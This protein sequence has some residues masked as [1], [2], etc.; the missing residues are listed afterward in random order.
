M[1]RQAA[2]DETSTVLASLDLDRVRLNG[3]TVNKLQFEKGRLVAPALGPKKLVGA[4]L[5][6]TSS[7][8]Q[9]V[10][11]ALCSAEP[12]AQDPQLF[13]YRIEVW[14]AESAT[15]A[16]P[17]IATH[18]APSPK[19][20]AVAGVWD[21]SGARLDV[22]G[23]FT[24]ACENGAIAKCIGWG[25][26]PWELKDGQSLEAL[27]QACTRMARADYCGSGRSHTREDAPI[28]MYDELGLLTRTRVATAGWD[29]E[30]ASFEAE[31]TP[32]GASCLSG[33]RDGQPVETVL[34]ECPDR[35]EAGPKELGEGDRCT[36]RRK[37]GGGGAALLRNRSYGRH[38]RG[39]VPGPTP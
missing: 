23:K 21:R 1:K 27:H 5:Q 25:Y 24:F 33:T 34:A 26:K 32:E 30:L 18:R 12:D 35:F 7:D 9:P 16:N 39:N 6:G 14:H 36:V 38:D 17:C 11:V 2:E 29:P 31:W 4:V 8:G 3:G 13:R 28:D 15:W 10:E 37:G 22:P 19:A 20:L